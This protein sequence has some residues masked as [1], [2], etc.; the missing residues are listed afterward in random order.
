MEVH[1]LQVAL[2]LQRAEEQLPVTAS[3]LESLSPL[4][5]WCVLRPVLQSPLYLFLTNADVFK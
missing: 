3:S 5:G 1:P 4:S 2:R